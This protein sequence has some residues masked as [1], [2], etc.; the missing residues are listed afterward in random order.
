MV[1]IFSQNS[2]GAHFFRLT[3][4]LIVAAIIKDGVINTS[5]AQLSVPKCNA[6]RKKEKKVIFKDSRIL[7]E[8]YKVYT[9]LTC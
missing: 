8:N 9:F 3:N 7:L 6:Q 2:S 1:D 4:Q 5:S